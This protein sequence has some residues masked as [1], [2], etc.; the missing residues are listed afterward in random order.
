[1]RVKASR[2]PKRAA[3]A[4]TLAENKVVGRTRHSVVDT[5]G[6]LLV[7]VAHAASRLD[8]AG[9]LEVGA[10]RRGR[11]PRLRKVWADQSYRQTMLDW[12]RSALD[13]LVAVVPRTAAPGFHVLP[14]RWKVERT[15]GWFNR[16]R[17]LRKAD[18]VYVEVSAD[19]VYLASMQ[20]MMRRLAR[21]K[22][23]S[24]PPVS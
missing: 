10:T 5:L 14:Q 7:V 18:E 17:R 6:R 23:Q 21:A 15:L 8:P 4:A 12:F 13:C 1:L 24:S 3:S 22:Q 19:W 16:S 11:F 9:A 20:V 2:R